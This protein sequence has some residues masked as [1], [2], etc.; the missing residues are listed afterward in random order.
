MA[1]FTDILGALIKQGMSGSGG[2]RMTNAMGAGSS[3]GGLGDLM[4]TLTQMMGGGGSGQKAQAGAGGLGGM[5]G[6]VLGSLGNNKAALGGLG[7]LAGALLGGGSSSAK[8]AV[9]GGG[10]AMLASL[11][12][13]ALKKFGQAPAQA[14]RALL[15][16]QNAQE[17][18]ALE[19]DAE[20]I[21]KAMINAAKAD[22]QIDQ[23][24]IN[25][26]IGKLDDEGLTQKE[27]DFFV[28][29]ANKPLD[30]AGVVAS[31]GN[32]PVMAAQIYAASLL[33]IEVDTQAEKDYMQQLASGLDLHPQVASQI[34][35]TLGM[36]A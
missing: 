34:E 36:Q 25:K 11:A 23:K 32:Q 33:A 20:V 13:S 30:L 9:G 1:G 21:V 10:M 27:K 15:E 19:D 7:A 12:F 6:E 2:S 31:A 5:L 8:G 24:E 35:S 26:I 3:G 29:E 22:G 14:P 28:S 16:A 4:G 18:Q 17:Q